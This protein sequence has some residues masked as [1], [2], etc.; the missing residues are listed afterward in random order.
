M[1][2]P[3]CGTLTDQS[4]KY[5]KSCGLKLA[6]HA[7]LLEKPDGAMAQS[8]D[9][10]RRESQLLTGVMLV[11]GTLFNLTGF[12]CIYGVKALNKMAIDSKPAM[13]RTFLIYLAASLIAGGLGV[14]NLLR[15]GFFRNL[16]ERQLRLQLALIEQKRKKLETNAERVPPEVKS[17]PLVSEVASN[18][19]ETTRKLQSTPAVTNEIKSN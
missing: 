5:C 15:G 12:F 1:Y 18:T 9:Q 10:I 16:K 14:F 3:K 8:E 19:E 11:T 2:C 7:S 4:P 17:P 6:D 13:L